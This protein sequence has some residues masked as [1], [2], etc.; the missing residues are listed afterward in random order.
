MQTRLG[1]FLESMANVVVGFWVN[2]GINMLILPALGFAVSFGVNFELVMVFT[3]VSIVRSYC[4]R[5]WFNGWMGRR[6]VAL[7]IK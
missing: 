3:I 1:S 7:G 2:F 6:L 5:R 4:L